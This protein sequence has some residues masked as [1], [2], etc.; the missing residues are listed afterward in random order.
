MS[1]RYFY[2]QQ[3][4]QVFFYRVL[5]V[6]FTS[7]VYKGL[8]TDAKILYGFLLDRMNLSAKNDWKDVIFTVKEIQVSLQCKDNKATKL[9][10]ELEKKYDKKIAFFSKSYTLK[11]MQDTFFKLLEN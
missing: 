4:E 10:N 5:K 8:S 2:G 6:L 3:A 9:L 11:Q 1:T 7:E